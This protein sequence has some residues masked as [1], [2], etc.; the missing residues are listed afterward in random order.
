[1][2]CEHGAFVAAYPSDEGWRGF[3]RTTAYRTHDIAE[4]KSSDSSMGSNANIEL[5]RTGI[6]GE[7][8]RVFMFRDQW[9]GVDNTYGCV[10]LF[11]AEDPVGKRARVPFDGKNF[12]FIPCR[13]D[14][15]LYVIT[16]FE[17]LTVY[18]TSDPFEISKWEAVACAS[19]RWRLNL[20]GRPSEYRGG[21]PG[22]PM[23][24][25][26]D[27]TSLYRGWYF[28][29]GHRTWNEDVLVKNTRL[30]SLRVPGPLRHRPFFWMASLGHHDITIRVQE[31]LH[32]E[33][34][35]FKNNIIDPT[36]I[37][38]MNGSHHLI[39]AE[40]E[41]VWYGP[42]NYVN[43]VYQIGWPCGFDIIHS[44]YKNGDDELVFAKIHK[45]E[46]PRSLQCLAIKIEKNLA[47][48]LAQ[49]SAEEDADTI[50]AAQ[51]LVEVLNAHVLPDFGETSS[52]EGYYPFGSKA[53]KL[54]GF[55]WAVSTDTLQNDRILLMPDMRFHNI[56]ICNQE[57][58]NL[59]SDEYPA[60]N[61]RFV[62][63]IPTYDFLYAA[64]SNCPSN[65]YEPIS[66]FIFQFNQK[67]VPLP[68][69][70]ASKPY[71]H[72]R[73][74]RGVNQ[75]ELISDSSNEALDT[76]KQIV[77]TLQRVVLPFWTFDLS[78]YYCIGDNLYPMPKTDMDTDVC[79]IQSGE[80]RKWPDSLQWPPKLIVSS[81]DRIYW[82]SS[83]LRRGF[84]HISVEELSRKTSDDAD[85][86]RWNAVVASAHLTREKAIAY[87]SRCLRK[88]QFVKRDLYV[89]IR[90]IK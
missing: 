71:I 68:C 23:R 35:V 64:L 6:D 41:K 77:D 45:Y 42:Q 14:G 49:D 7:D 12:T 37:V 17:P 5:V 88:V 84:T 57:W 80:Y 50:A 27:N 16:W 43:S 55:G 39:C 36:C 82:F 38:E 70:P 87:T 65:I 73:N 10:S 21:T 18:R 51:A 22:Y 76:E 11:A 29:F 59:R 33:H 63:Y 48:C 62:D 26:S 47:T 15:Y 75:I 54:H 28:G 79:F 53:V 44:T 9:Y 31:L 32:L 90:S 13:E 40:S 20:L 81:D 4:F 24:H 83:F 3:F 46:H 30:G 25:F 67:Y 2:P 1:M 60:Y 56:P 74:E 58:L 89:T 34:T 66:K 85:H 52:L 78:G 8:P 86:V 72:I 61:N 69:A 19:S